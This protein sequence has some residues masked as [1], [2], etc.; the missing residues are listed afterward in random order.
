[1]GL[2][3]LGGRFKIM[4]RF[5]FPRWTN[6]LVGLLLVAGA[7]GAVFAGAMGGLITDPQTLNVGYQ[8]KQPVPFSHAIHATATIPS[9]MRLMRQFPQRLLVLTAT[10]QLMI[11]ALRL[12]RRFTR[13][14]RS[15]TQFTRAGLRAA[16]L[17]GNVST[18]CQNLST[19]TMLL[20]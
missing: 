2:D 8:P 4:Q 10:A 17:A 18:T 1:M 6:P 20:T 7:A 12:W 15:S 11:K 13:K 19:S 9:S 14:A 3:S 5:L 16:A